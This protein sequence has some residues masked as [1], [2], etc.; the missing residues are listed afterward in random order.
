MNLNPVVFHSGLFNEIIES[1][2]G[3]ISFKRL[4]NYWCVYVISSG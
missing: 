4:L 2:N 1:V 3:N